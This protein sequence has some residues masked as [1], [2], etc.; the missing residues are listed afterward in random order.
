[1]KYN[2]LKLLAS[3]VLSAV[4]VASLGLLWGCGTAGK[5]GSDA[6]DADNADSAKTTVLKV[7]ASPAPHAEILDSIKATLAEEGIELQIIEYSDYVLPN[8]ALQD[9]DIDANYFQHKPYLDDFN[10][11]HKS[12]LVSVAAIHFE[13]LAVYAGKSSAISALPDGAKIA[14]PNDTTNEARALLLLQDQGLITLP[15]DAGLTVTPRDIVDNP[16]NLEFLEVEAAALPRG[17]EEVD[18]AVIN[19]N[20]ALAAD[21]P[22][23][24]ILATEDPDSLAATTYANCLVVKEGN[25]AAPAIKALI[26]ALTSQQTRDFINE[27]YQGVVVPVF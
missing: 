25:E 26:K 10:A 5:S 12:A 18:L 1:M 21:L 14:V 4:L 20:F 24:L 19:G 22:T 9:G 11:E 23:S 15:A 27:R 6:K 7:G 17:L 8:T 3:L 13:P 2:R 16:K